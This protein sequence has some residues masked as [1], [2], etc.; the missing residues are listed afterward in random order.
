MPWVSNSVRRKTRSGRLRPR[1]P[2]PLWLWFSFKAASIDRMQT[3]HAR[4]GP[5]SIQVATPDLILTIT[6]SGRSAGKD[7]E[8]TASGRNATTILID[9]D[10]ISK[11]SSSNADTR[12]DPS[13][14]TS[15]QSIVTESRVESVLQLRKKFSDIGSDE[16]TLFLLCDLEGPIIAA[17]AAQAFGLKHRPGCL[18]WLVNNSPISHTWFRERAPALATLEPLKSVSVQSE[19]TAVDPAVRA[20]HMQSPLDRNSRK[21]DNGLASPNGYGCADCGPG[22]GSSRYQGF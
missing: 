21:P 12:P 11:P 7:A 9:D 22:S 14:A 15:P 2:L 13:K 4:R 20:K 8:Q 3:A 16:I 6:A 19:S 5:T 17:H 18:Q 1:L 10:E